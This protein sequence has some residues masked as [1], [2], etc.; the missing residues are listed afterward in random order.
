MWS[1]VSSEC[2]GSGPVEQ[3]SSRLRVSAGIAPAS[4]DCARVNVWSSLYARASVGLESFG[5]RVNHS[6][7][8]TVNQWLTSGMKEVRA[9]Q[10]ALERART[11]LQTAVDR[12]RAAGHTW[13]EIGATLGM[14]RQAAFKRFGRVTDPTTGHTLEGVHM[15]LATIQETTERVFDLISSGDHTSLSA[16]LH[17]DVRPHLTP[18]VIA[19]TWARVLAEVGAKESYADTH[20]VFPAGEPITSDDQVLGT[21]VGVTTLQCEAGEVM[22]RVAVDASQQV[23]GL[24]L[25]PVGQTDLPF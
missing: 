8:R 23:V 6:L 18:A 7:T 1:V 25:V 16:L 3:D 22:G 15:S 10:Q 9:A 21:V 20:V 5:V 12:A 17:P 13:A 24:L 11:G 4:L 19:D 14:S 2:S